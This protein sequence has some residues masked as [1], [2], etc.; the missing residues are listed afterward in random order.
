MTADTVE[1]R[2]RRIV[3]DHLGVAEERVRLE[4]EL[5][6]DLG[7]DS[8]DRI[9]MLMACEEDFGIEIADDEAE[10]FVRVCDVVAFVERAL[11][12]KAS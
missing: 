2:V 11:V 1:E 9:E 7:A 6:L 3:A 10:G 5:N 8:L 12:Q 4:A